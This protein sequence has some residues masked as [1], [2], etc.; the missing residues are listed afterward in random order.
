MGG[1]HLLWG[2]INVAKLPILPALEEASTSLLLP[3]VTEE[4]KTPLR[5]RA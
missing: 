3:N 1:R 4:T 5:V 2:S